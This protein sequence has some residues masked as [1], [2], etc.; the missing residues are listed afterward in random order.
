MTTNKEYLASELEQMTPARLRTL[1]SHCFDQP[2]GNDYQTYLLIPPH[3]FVEVLQQH[4]HGPDTNVVFVD[5]I[6]TT[7]PDLTYAAVAQVFVDAA[8]LHRDSVNSI[9]AG[10]YLADPPK[11]QCDYQ[12]LIAD[13]QRTMLRE[14][15]IYPTDTLRK[16]E[17]HLCAILHTIDDRELS[18]NLTNKMLRYYAN[19][20]YEV[21]VLVMSDDLKPAIDK[22]Q[23]A[24]NLVHPQHNTQ[25]DARRREKLSYILA[26]TR[27][28][29]VR[30]SELLQT[31]TV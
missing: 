7:H 15:Q 24:E 30:L 25:A 19:L 11:N 26:K 3:W 12:T 18:Q 10:Q 2:S 1:A 13:G 14:A 27:P 20:I 23:Q 22:L 6:S 17:P 5:H 28:L 8:D 31:N 29:L 4:T 9:M 21:F 16:L